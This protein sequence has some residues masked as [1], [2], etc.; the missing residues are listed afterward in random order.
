MTF[1]EFN[2]GQ[3]QA[4]IDLFSRVFSDSEGEQEGK[5][6]GQ[7]VSDLIATTDSQDLQGYVAHAGDEIT[8]CIFF[9]RLTLEDN[10]KAFILS[11]VAVS[12]SHQR[13]GIGQQL[14]AYGI[15]Q[16][17]QQGTELVMTYGD[18][19]YYS[20][21]GFEPVSEECIKAPQPLSFPHGWLAQSLTGEAIQPK[22]GVA[23]CVPALN[24]QIYW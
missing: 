7:L 2:P 11:P 19:N 1:S 8:G 23:R 4:V 18:P 12:T 24:N 13:Q 16:L 10:S 21:T 9:S 5:V 17:K 15:E 14:I 22:A 6:I 3:T 20:K